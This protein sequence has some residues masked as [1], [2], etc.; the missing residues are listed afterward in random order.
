MRRLAGILQLSAR[1]AQKAH[2]QPAAQ[3]PRLWIPTR[4]GVVAWKTRR[5]VGG[6]ART[7]PDTRQGPDS[8]DAVDGPSHVQGD[9][10][11]W[12][13]SPERSRAEE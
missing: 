8:G 7:S 12:P 2:D 11:R 10:R 5:L 6:L 3:L 4:H 9:S 13:L 1:L